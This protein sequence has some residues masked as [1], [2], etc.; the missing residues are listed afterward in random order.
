MISIRELF[1]TEEQVKDE[2]VGAT[3]TTLVKKSE[4]PTATRTGF[5][6]DMSDRLK[7]AVKKGRIPQAYYN[8]QRQELMKQ[9][10]G[11]TTGMYV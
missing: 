2:K 11:K 3:G 4:S 7:E 8:K 5:Y 9:R 6:K 10:Y 1:E